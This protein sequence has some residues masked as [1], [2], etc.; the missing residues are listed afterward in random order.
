MGNA[1]GAFF[2][3]EANPLPTPVALLLMNQT[4]DSTDTV[5]PNGGTFFFFSLVRLFTFFPFFPFFPFSLFPF[6]SKLNLGRCHG[7]NR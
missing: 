4:A 3:A 2:D 5:G 7:D 1:G 6:F